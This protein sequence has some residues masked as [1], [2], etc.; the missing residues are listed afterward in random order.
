MAS[1]KEYVEVS[2]TFGSKWVTKVISKG[3]VV[4]TSVERT[5]L[6]KAMRDVNFLN[7]ED[8]VLRVGPCSRVIV[9]TWPLEK[10]DSLWLH[11][12]LHALKSTYRR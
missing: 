7:T 4:F 1:R 5:H 9:N 2:L 10:S 12:T 11:N 8:V 6:V 3:L